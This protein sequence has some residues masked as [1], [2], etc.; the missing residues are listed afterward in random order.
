VRDEAT[1]VVFVGDDLVVAAAQVLLTDRPS[2]QNGVPDAED[3]VVFTVSA[4]DGPSPQL[5]E[6]VEL[7][8]GKPHGR[9]VILLMHASQQPDAELELLVILEIRELLKVHEQRD[10]DSIPALGDDDPNIEIL[11]RGL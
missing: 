8:R 1:T 5:R 2:Q 6:Q 9:S 7:L 10:W 11:L 3:P 4:A